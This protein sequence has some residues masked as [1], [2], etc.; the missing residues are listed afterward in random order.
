[1]TNARTNDITL[2]TDNLFS[3]NR[4][5][6]DEFIEKNLVIKCRIRLDVGKKKIMNQSKNL[7]K[8]DFVNWPGYKI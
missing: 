6:S 2:S 5:N 8:L 4:M 7:Q 3:L 1:M